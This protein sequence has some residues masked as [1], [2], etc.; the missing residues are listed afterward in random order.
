MPRDTMAILTD[1]LMTES[2]LL[3][4]C[5]GSREAG[6]VALSARG[7]ERGDAH[8]PRKGIGPRTSGLRTLGSL[9]SVV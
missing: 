9:P 1:A 4:F 8:G 6:G 5:L 3:S 2:F 7:A